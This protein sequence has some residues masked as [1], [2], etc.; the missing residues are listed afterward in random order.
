M[1]FVKRSIY[2]LLAIAMIFSFNAAIEYE[3]L[4]VEKM[5]DELLELMSWVSDTTPFSVMIELKD[6]VPQD[7]LK[8]ALDEVYKEYDMDAFYA[9]EKNY[10]GNDKAYQEDYPELLAHYDAYAAAR[11]DTLASFYYPHNYAFLEK[12]DLKVEKEEYVGSG[13]PYIHSVV[14]NKEIVSKMLYDSDVARVTHYSAKKG[15][16]AGYTDTGD[17]VS[18]AMQYVRGDINDLGVT[19]SGIKVGLIEEGTPK[20]S[21]VTNVTNLNSSTVTEHATRTSL[22]IRLLSPSCH[23]YTYRL[24]SNHSFEGNLDENETSLVGVAYE[25]L[26]TEGVHVIN[27]SYASANSLTTGTPQNDVTEQ[28]DRMIKQ[29]NIPLVVAAGNSTEITNVQFGA[30]LG[31]NVS[32]YAVGNNTI[33][34]GGMS[35]PGTANSLGGFWYGLF[36]SNTSSG[37]T[38]PTPAPLDVGGWN[39]SGAME[40]YLFSCWKEDANTPNKPELVAPAGIY[41]INDEYD[42]NSGLLHGTSYATPHV[43]STIAWM[44]ARNVYMQGKTEQIKAAVIGSAYTR[45]N[46][47][48]KTYAHDHIYGNGLIN[49]VS[50]RDL[51][52]DAT[53]DYR[54]AGVLNAAYCYNVAY[55]GQRAEFTFSAQGQSK[56]YNVSVSNRNQPFRIGIAWE[57]NGINPSSRSQ[58]T[59]AIKKQGSNTNITEGIVDYS[60]TMYQAITLTPEMIQQYGTGTYTVTITCANYQSSDANVVGMTWNTINPLGYAPFNAQ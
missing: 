26:A 54:G 25:R 58:Y 29:Y 48:K 51:N 9:S 21:T 19:G 39:T 41:S 45:Q 59:I 40:L 56:T 43:T 49:W 11:M 7:K 37:Q 18:D 24:G 28:L 47:I 6:K 33:C 42:E 50:D 55:L 31:Y 5:N 44:L 20:I 30:N 57:S 4:A 32:D 15:K 3:T 60:D 14:V 36:L 27:M 52:G 53:E 38:V 8:K 17:N 13:V 34:V 12:Y 1:K 16:D 23:I 2:L 46:V 22:I 35:A 10:I